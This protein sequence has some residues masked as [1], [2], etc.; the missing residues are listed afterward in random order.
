MPQSR[1]RKTKAKKRPKGLYPASKAKAQTA[2]NR[3]VRVVAIVVVLALAATAVAYL[4]ANR[5]SSAEVTTPSGLKYTDIV[6]GTG[7]TPQAGQTV[8]V[9]YTGTLE[10]GTKFDSSFDH[11]QPAEFLIGVGRVIK[12]WD[13]GLMTM[14]VGGKRHFVIPSKLGYGPAGR[15]PDIPGNSTLIF[16][17]ELLGVK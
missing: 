6:V 11:G 16:D 15:P 13:E 7:A 3:Q 5:G 17:V 12:G 4:V 8:T 9:N 1:H 10:N 14:K 2:R